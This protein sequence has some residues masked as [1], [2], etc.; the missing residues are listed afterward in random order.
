M[1]ERSN[2]E[3]LIGAYLADELN[4]DLRDS[5]ESWIAESQKN[6]DIFKK[7]EI[8]WKLNKIDPKEKI[9]AFATLTNRIRQNENVKP[10]NKKAKKTYLTVL[11]IAAGFAI[12]ISS[13]FLVRYIHDDGQQTIDKVMITKQV[14]YGKKMK[15]TLQDGTRIQLNAGSTLSYPEGFGG[16]EVR[17]VSLSGEAFFEV[18]KAERRF[19]VEVEGNEIVVLGT[20]F[21][22][23]T[24]DESDNIETVVVTGSVEFIPAQQTKKTRATNIKSGEK[25]YYNIGD[26]FLNKV[27]L[28]NFD[29]ISWKEGIL[30]FKGEPLKNVFPEL[31]KWYGVDFQ[32]TNKQIYQCNLTAKFDNQSLDQVLDYINVIMPLNHA[33]IDSNLIVIRGKGCYEFENPSKE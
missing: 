5:V 31:E 21:N 12:L 33:F 1:N 17:R 32:V 27:K 16:E 18:V 26:N 24:N 30:T 14:P 15:L 19:I 8:I 2:I 25:L 13:Y 10:K 6:H 11:K 23:K 22:V 20:S 4:P 3:E 28:T 9:N 7:Y 29:D